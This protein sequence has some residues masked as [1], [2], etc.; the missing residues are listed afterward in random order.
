MHEH[1][2]RKHDLSA[3]AGSW[4]KLAAKDT[5]AQINGYGLSWGR[6]SENNMLQ[7]H[8][9]AT[10]CSSP[11]GHHSPRHRRLANL[12]VFA[13]RLT[14]MNRPRRAAQLKARSTEPTPES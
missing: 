1:K 9:V 11:R 13:M 2:F 12:V 3:S 10:C 5:K 7:P 14:F 6:V 4:A 8:S